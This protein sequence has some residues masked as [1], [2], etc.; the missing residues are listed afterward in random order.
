METL[1]DRIGCDRIRARP[2]GWITASCPFAKTKHA[3]GEDRNPSFGVITNEA[4]TYFRCQGCKVKGPLQSLPYALEIAGILSPKQAAGVQRFISSA[5]AVDLAKLK[6]RVEATSFRPPVQAP[7][8]PPKPVEIDGFQLTGALAEKFH[9]KTELS[10]LP[11]DSLRWF[12]KLPDDV[13]AG[14]A[15]AKRTI[16]A[17]TYEDWQI[18][19]QPWVYRIG[20]PVR[21]RSKRLVGIT[22]RVHDH[23]SCPYC[24]VPYVEIVLPIGEDGKIKRR[25]K[26]PGCERERPAKFLHTKGFSRD[27]YLFGEHRVVLGK[28]VILVEGHFD[29]VALHQWKYNALAVM[30]SDLALFQLEKVCQWFTSVVI[31]PDPDKA[32]QQMG[33][34]IANQ[35]KGRI[36][37][38]VRFP[39]PGRDPDQMDE[40]ELDAVL[41]PP[42]LP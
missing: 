34:N 33:E 38:D 16:T 25:W 11:E 8:V 31:F 4:G 12:T 35:L 42:D 21:D 26:C 36:P 30:G 18:R 39:L 14:P 10:V 24:Q 1:L 5:N 32:G 2:N 15:C 19:W 20:I 29:V 22:G 6:K 13:L 3:G 40:A 37:F 27:Y 41:G 28:R 17:K 23:A 9:K 7:R